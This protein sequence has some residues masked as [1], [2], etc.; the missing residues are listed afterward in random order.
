M[1]APAARPCINCAVQINARAE[2]CT[3]CGAEQPARRRI[4]AA[5]GR[6][7]PATL[8]A[9]LAGGLVAAA[10]AVSGDNPATDSTHRLFEVRSDMTL[11]TLVPQNWQGGH[12]AA[13]PHVTREMFVDPR[14]AGYSMTI[15][16]QRRARGSVV[17]RAH[18]VLAQIQRRAGFV[19]DSSGR[20]RFPGGRAGW[21]IEYRV[22]GVPHAMYL[23]SAC[24][25]IVAMS[26][27]V[28]APTRA[29]LA[30][31][32]AQLPVATGPRC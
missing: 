22:A 24:R 15:E 4:L 2:R 12:V 27:D 21:L 17:G 9:L 32:L 31:P 14:Q 10:V 19:L 8:G 5:L 25:P 29:E 6:Y 13:P 3:L 1:S 7:L 18:G 16:V 30:G 28:S 26:V 20:A 11:V 23:F